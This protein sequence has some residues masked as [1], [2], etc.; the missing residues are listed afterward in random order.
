M[1][2]RKKKHNVVVGVFETR[3]RADQA[4]AD[5]K[6]AGFA[7]G[8]IGMVYRNAE[9]ETVKTGVA[10]DTHAGEGA[11]IGAAAG[12]TGGALVGLGIVTGL[13]PVVV[14]V[15]AIGT[16]GTVLL[17]AAGGAAI[18]GMAGALI[19]WGIPEEDASFYEQ[20]VKAGRIMVLVEPGDRAAEARSI[21]HRHGGFDRAAWSAVRAD[22]ANT[23]TEGGFRAEDGRVVQLREEHL[24]ANKEMVAKGDV[25]VRKEV[26]TTHEQITVPVE[27]EEVV[28]ERR[29]ANGRAG[30]GAIKAEEIRIPVK[31]E[32]V[33]VGKETVVKEEVTVGKRKTRGSQT[34]EGDVQKE[35]LVVEPEGGAHVRHTTRG[36]RK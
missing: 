27:R 22:R 23:L 36:G 32:R 7:D 21:L 17:N 8:D 12:A 15:L 18:A 14:P 2:N 9:G 11:A 6:A 30:A 31:E 34:V 3:S 16:L 29:P 26:H 20:E 1:P 19:G 35:E 24:K 33:N 5:L 28:I 25:R 4:V 10:D 13:I